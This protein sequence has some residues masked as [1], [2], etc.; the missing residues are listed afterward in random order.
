MGHTEKTLEQFWRRGASDNHTEFSSER[1]SLKSLFRILIQGP[2]QPF[3]RFLTNVSACI[4][5]PLQK[6]GLAH[7]RDD[8][9]IL[10]HNA[11]GWRTEETNIAVLI[12]HRK[13][14]HCRK[15][16]LT[17]AELSGI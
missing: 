12:W 16:A 13:A 5:L 14:G 17:P 7:L 9:G 10:R 8:S 4:S 2:C 6:C 1:Q 11:R 3:F 15:W